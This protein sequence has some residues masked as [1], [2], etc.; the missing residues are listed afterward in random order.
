MY[1]S[2]FNIWSSTDS[3]TDVSIENYEIQIFRSFFHVYL[4]YMFRFYFLTTLDILKIIL[5]VFIRL[6]H[7]L[8]HACCDRRQSALV[9]L[10]LEKVVAFIYC[11]VLWPRSFLIIIL[12]MNWRNLQPTSFLSWC[13]N[14]ILGSV[15]RLDSHVLGAVHW[16]E[17]LLLQYKSNYVL[18]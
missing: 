17:R 15:R 11:R 13:V 8:L 16:K 2:R 3:S 1:L 9:H 12:W 10:S 6:L 18:G 4:S 7:L 14:H 5:R